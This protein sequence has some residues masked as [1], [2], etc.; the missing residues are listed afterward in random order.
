[1]ARNY[2]TG[3]DGAAVIAAVDAVVT[4][5][6]YTEKPEIAR[7]RGGGDGAFSRKPIATDWEANVTVIM[8]ETEAPLDISDYRG[9]SV[10][11]TLKSDDTPKLRVVGSGLVTNARYSSPIG[12]NVTIELKLECNDADEANLPVITAA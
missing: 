4:D 1:M 3:K 5:W 6:D 12:D 2:Y 11:F 9:V 10:A 8:P 7:S